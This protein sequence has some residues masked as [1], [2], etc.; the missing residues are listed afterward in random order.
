MDS[1]LIVPVVNVVL[2]LIAGFISI[3]WL[4]DAVEVSRTV[5]IEMPPNSDAEAE[6]VFL[7]LMREARTEMVMYDDGEAGKGSLYQSPRV[8]D[9]IKTK[10][11]EHNGFRVICVLNELNDTLF[12]REL[13]GTDGVK[14]CRRIS[15]PSRVHYK[16]IDR[17]K[18]YVS[19]HQLGE[20][21]RSRRMIDCTDAPSRRPGRYPLALQRYFDD[22]ERHA[23]Y[24]AA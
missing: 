3:P 15:K 6:H 1:S 23:E 5:V 10:L 18:A 17:R 9:A 21:A 12:K 19:C 11:Q 7:D 4:R 24:H 13:D 16:I 20:A 2:V 8:V 22:F 14:L